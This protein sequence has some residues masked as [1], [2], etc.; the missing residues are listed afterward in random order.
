MNVEM[1][2]CGASARDCWCGCGCGCGC[3]LGLADFDT[4]REERRRDV[5]DVLGGTG[6]GGR[7]GM[8]LAVGGV[9]ERSNS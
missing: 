6:I 2:K 4:G 3:G 5:E 9:R 8:E 1:E 7:G